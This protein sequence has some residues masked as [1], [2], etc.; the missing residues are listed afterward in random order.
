[1]P[2]GRVAIPQGSDSER[3]VHLEDEFEAW[4]GPRF[5]VYTDAMAKR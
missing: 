2:A 4:P 3:L 1:M 5:H